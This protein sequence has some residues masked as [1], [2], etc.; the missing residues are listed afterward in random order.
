MLVNEFGELPI[1]HDLIE[2]EGDTLISIA[3]DA[4]CA[5]GDDLGAALL[6][7]Q[8]MSP[9]PDHILIES[10]RGDPGRDPCGADL[11]RGVAP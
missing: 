3:G 10:G 4:C 8:D 7:V 6:R 5:I 9:P 11:C 1:D 2:A